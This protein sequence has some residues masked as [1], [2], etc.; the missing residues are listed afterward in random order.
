MV[1]WRLIHQQGSKKFAELG[2][3]TNSTGLL[4]AL[5]LL[6]IIIHQTPCYG[7]LLEGVI[8]SPLNSSKALVLPCT[9]YMRQQQSKAIALLI[10]RVHK[11]HAPYSRLTLPSLSAHPHA[12]TF[13]PHVPAGEVLVQ[14]CCCIWVVLVS[15]KPSHQGG[16][17]CRPR[18]HCCKRVVFPESHSLL[19]EQVHS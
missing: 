14:N 8:C 2:S 15:L 16:C 12:C 3:P 10:P 4:K 7:G 19:I 11:N 17:G 1:R 13:V 18:G 5:I 9:R 6:R